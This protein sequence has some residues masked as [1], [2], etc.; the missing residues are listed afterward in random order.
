MEKVTNTSHIMFYNACGKTKKKWEN[1]NQKLCYDK[2]SRRGEI[3][4]RAR[5]KKLKKRKKIFGC[6]FNV[7]LS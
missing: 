4:E 5:K 3:K 6:E 1:S 7:M 2:I